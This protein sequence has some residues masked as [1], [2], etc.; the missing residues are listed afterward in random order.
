[1]LY[2]PPSKIRASVA[3]RFEDVSKIATSERRM[4]LIKQPEEEIR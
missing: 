4:G 1:M 3:C 2:P